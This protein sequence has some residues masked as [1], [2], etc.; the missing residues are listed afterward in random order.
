MK[1]NAAVARLF[2]VLDAELAIGKG[3]KDITELSVT[4]AGMMIWASGLADNK[5]AGMIMA[6]DALESGEGLEKFRQFVKAQGG[7]ESVT[8]D[9]DLFGK[10]VYKEALPADK[11]GYIESLDARTV[12]IASRHAGAGRAVKNDKIDLKAGVIL[13]KKI[14]D[15]VVKGDTL[16]EIFRLRDRKSVV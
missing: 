14:G 12:G 7:N 16:A 6:K 4:V 15:R 1:R 3:P 9:Y 5:E 2:A 11:D 10:A 8:D 13:H